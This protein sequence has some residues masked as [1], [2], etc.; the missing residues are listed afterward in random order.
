VV[1]ELNLAAPD[2]LAARPVLF[3]KPDPEP[4][5]DS[6]RRTRTFQEFM[7]FNQLPLWRA[8]TWP[9]LE[10]GRLVELFD[11]R[12]GTPASPGFMAKAVVDGRGQVVE[13]DF[14]FGTPRPR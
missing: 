2:P 6:A 14:K 5:I 8:T 9:H 4:A 10:N 12:F 13:T 7:R 1:Q 3:H 11:M